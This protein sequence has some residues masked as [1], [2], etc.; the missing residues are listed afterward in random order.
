M[1][2]LRKMWHTI[3]H[4]GIMGESKEDNKEKGAEKIFKETMAGKFPT[5]LKNIIQKAQRTPK[6]IG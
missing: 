1:N 6:R 2:H 4:I 5:V 3:K